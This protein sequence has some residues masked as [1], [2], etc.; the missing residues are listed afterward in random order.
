MT[1]SFQAR[2]T[3]ELQLYCY[4]ENLGSV[5]RAAIAVIDMQ[6]PCCMP[7]IRPQP[8]FEGTSLVIWDES[9]VSSECLLE[10]NLICQEYHVKS[11]WF[12]VLSVFRYPH[13]V[14]C[15]YFT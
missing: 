2:S 8:P 15:S 14:L 12:L 1:K 7:W 10:Q 5:M 4:A 3:A 6:S 13:K 11:G 9:V